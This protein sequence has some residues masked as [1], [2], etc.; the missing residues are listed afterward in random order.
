M[1]F[2]FLFFYKNWIFPIN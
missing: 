2:H 1:T